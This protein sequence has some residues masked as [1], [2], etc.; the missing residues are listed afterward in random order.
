MGEYCRSAYGPD[1]EGSKKHTPKSDSINDR[2][3]SSFNKTGSSQIRVNH[4]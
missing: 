1:R 2:T 3:S 4:L